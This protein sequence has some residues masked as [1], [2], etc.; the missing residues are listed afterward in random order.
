MGEPRPGAFVHQPDPRL[1]SASRVGHAV[2]GS[3]DGRGRIPATVVHSHTWYTGMAGH[4]T[5][6]LYPIPHVL[7]AHSLEPLRPWKAEQ[8]GCGYRV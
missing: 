1:Q 7:T 8:L 6:L 4:L 5:A 2:G 3:G